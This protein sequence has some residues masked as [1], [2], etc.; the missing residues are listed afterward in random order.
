MTEHLLLHETSKL[1]ELSKKLSRCEAVSRFDTDREP[2]GWTLA[3]SFAHLEESFRKFLDEQLPRLMK[4]QL[5]EEELEELLHEIG[6]EFRHVI[7]H[8]KDPLYY[9]YL[10]DEPEKK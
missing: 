7:Y 5:L 9:R 3:H 10:F 8:I 2:E 4:G 6:E 1:K